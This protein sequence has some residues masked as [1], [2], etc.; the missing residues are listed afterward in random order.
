MRRLR[1]GEAEDRA[2]S[3]TASK[4][5]NGPSGG[6]HGGQRQPLRRLRGGGGGAEPPSTTHHSAEAGECSSGR[7]SRGV[8]TSAPPA[9]RGGG[10]GERS[11]GIAHGAEAGRMVLRQVCAGTTP[12][13]A[14]LERR[15]SGGRDPK[16]HPSPRGRRMFL[17][18]GLSQGGNFSPSGAPGAGPGQSPGNHPPADSRTNTPR[19]SREGAGRE[20][21][22]PQPPRPTE[23]PPA[24]PEPPP[25]HP[26]RP[27]AP[28]TPCPS[29]SG[30]AT[31]ESAGAHRPPQ[32]PARRS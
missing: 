7:S 29:T 6:L 11:P 1:R 4:P 13:L 9:L 23:S 2:P 17:R 20:K 16:H 25:R 26:P 14:A 18:G 19:G 12:A 27:T 22:P 28:G 8:E 3:T 32:P 15:W 5:V 10:L 24:P 21:I 31:P 30:T